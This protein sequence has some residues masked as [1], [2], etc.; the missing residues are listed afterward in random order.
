MS[1]DWLF[2]NNFDK[3]MLQFYRLVRAQLIDCCQIEYK[4][5]E[6]ELL[7]DQGF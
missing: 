3:S 4:A 6:C 5:G 7:L 2:G 1:R